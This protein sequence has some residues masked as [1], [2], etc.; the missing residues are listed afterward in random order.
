MN[1]QTIEDLL[2]HTKRQMDAA[3]DRSLD[4]LDTEDECLLFLLTLFGSFLSRVAAQAMPGEETRP[5]AEAMMAM[6]VIFIALTHGSDAVN[7][8]DQGLIRR[9]ANLLQRALHAIG[10]RWDR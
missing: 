9:R 2:H 8:M 7:S 1:K 4:L 10:E 3:V 6:A 5:D